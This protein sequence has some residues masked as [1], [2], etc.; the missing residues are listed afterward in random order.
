M[1]GRA[2]PRG[3]QPDRRCPPAAGADDLIDDTVV[4]GGFPAEDLAHL[5]GTQA[6]IVEADHG[7]LAPHATPRQ[8]EGGLGAAADDEPGCRGEVL[9]KA[10]EDRPRVG[11]GELMGIVE[12]DGDLLDV[13]QVVRDG[14]DEVVGAGRGSRCAE[15]R[16]Q[17]RPEPLDD[18]AEAGEK[19]CG[20][21][22]GCI[23]FRAD[24][25]PGD[26]PRR[27]LCPGGERGRLP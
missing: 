1:R 17:P 8:G 18:A 23:I 20:D 16:L 12:H 24:A 10:V 11:V 22:G 9:E 2:E 15:Q 19:S 26:R 5:G 14:G 3:R 25:H 6:E 21:R 27:L 4:G 7:C 13:A